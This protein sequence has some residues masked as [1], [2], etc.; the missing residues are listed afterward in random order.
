VIVVRVNEHQPA[1]TK[2]LSEVSEQIK[3]RLMNEKASALAKEKAR[4]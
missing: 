2:A 3:T 1:A 4:T